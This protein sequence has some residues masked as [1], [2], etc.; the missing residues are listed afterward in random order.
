MNMTVLIGSLVLALILGLI[1]TKI[2]IPII[3]NKQMGQNIREEGPES[4]KAK[5]GTP[6]MGGVAL[7]GAALIAAVV[8]GISFG[9]FNVWM[10]VMILVTAGFGLVGFLDDYLK[11]IKKQNEG[12]NP[13]Q[14]IIFQIA[15]SLAVAI[16]AFVVNDAEVFIPFYG[17]CISFGVLYIPFIM[18]A[19]VAMTNAVNLTDG[20]DGLASGC[21][22][23]SSLFFALC[24]GTFFGNIS[25][26][27]FAVCI[28]GGCLGF[29]WWN[30]NPAKIFMGDT[31]SLALGGALV[32]EAISLKMEI[33]LL[34]VGLIYVCEA[35][36]VVIQVAVF[37]KTGKRV[38][39]MSPIHHHFELGGMKETNVVYMFWT[40]TL[41]CCIAGFLIVGI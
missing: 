23:L 22:A 20:L 5:Q 21:V 14:K 11:V 6:S 3:R 7:V 28:T 2:E 19:V 26:T 33:F 37:K 8:A 16:Y 1:F 38:F 13:K 24:A 40:V 36:S 39:R 32:I 17:K 9:A 15:I 31:G 10:L 35:L 25:T 12:L 27:I 30:K 41:V 29:L 34:L 4:H 18:F